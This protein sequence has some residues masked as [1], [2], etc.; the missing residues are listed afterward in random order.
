MPRSRQGLMLR[1]SSNDR[2]IRSPPST[3]VGTVPQTASFSS[4]AALNR[5]I[6]IAECAAADEYSCAQNRQGGCG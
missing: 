3:L 4:Q 1:F 6:C 5:A 2:Q